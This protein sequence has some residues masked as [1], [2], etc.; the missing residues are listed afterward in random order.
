MTP[1]TM[2]VDSLAVRYVRLLAGVIAVLALLCAY[3]YSCHPDERDGMFASMFSEE[4]AVI[5]LVI[6]IATGVMVV[7]E[8]GRWTEVRVEAER[9][10]LEPRFGGETRSVRF[11]EVMLARTTKTRIREALKLNLRDGRRITVAAPPFPDE[12][13]EQ[14]CDIFR[15]RGVM[16]DSWFHQRQK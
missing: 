5:G 11:D 8:S 10:V 9:L 1:F 2:Q 16:K 12:P 3:T 13:W 6:L 14:L 7:I 15:E 4:G